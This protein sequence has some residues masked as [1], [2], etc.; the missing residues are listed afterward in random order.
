MYL[1]SQ[2]AETPGKLYLHLKGLKKTY[3]MKVQ[4][5]LMHAPQK[6]CPGLRAG[7]ALDAQCFVV[8]RFTSSH[9]AQDLHSMKCCA[10]ALNALKRARMSSSS[11]SL[12]CQTMY[13]DDMCTCYASECVT[14]H[15][16]C[17]V[18]LVIFP[19]ACCRPHFGNSQATSQRQM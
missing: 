7:G 18:P 2:T 13:F 14:M 8:R 16:V 4:C 19:D 10:A 6:Q 12:G 1:R 11:H 3:E 9:L 17:F 5:A 15:S